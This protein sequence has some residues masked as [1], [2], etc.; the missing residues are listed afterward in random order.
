MQSINQSIKFANIP[1]L[2]QGLCNWGA[3]QM[4]WPP[5]SATGRAA[6]V[7]GTSPTMSHLGM[8]VKTMPRFSISVELQALLILHMFSYLFFL[9]SSWFWSETSCW[10]L[11]VRSSCRMGASGTEASPPMGL[12]AAEAHAIECFSEMPLANPTDGR[13]GSFVW[14][15]PQW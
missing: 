4:P 8:A 14:K 15:K 6:V 11:P 5:L 9:M 7:M 10:H 3:S 13:E 2:T 1:V 12:G